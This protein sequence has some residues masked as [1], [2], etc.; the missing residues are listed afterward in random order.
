MEN[1]SKALLIAGGILLAMLI[2]SIGIILYSNFANT[3]ETYTTRMDQTEKTKFNS[4]FEV[5]SGRDD[6]TAQDIVTLINFVAEYSKKTPIKVEITVGINSYTNG[7][8][9]SNDSINFLKNNLKTTFKCTNISYHKDG[10]IA[11]I[12]F[13]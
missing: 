13:N 11:S 7:W 1:A 8:N 6:I 2:L 3:A 9:D 4:N 10:E 5:Y 12:E